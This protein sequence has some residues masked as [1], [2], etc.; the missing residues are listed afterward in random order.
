MY[1]LL[2]FPIGRTA[3]L[4]QLFCYISAEF[5]INKDYIFL[6]PK[7]SSLEKALVCFV[8]VLWDEREIEKDFMIRNSTK[9]VSLTI[10]ILLS[11]IF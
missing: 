11:Y 6:W 2:V 8:I 1:F 5:T 10:D 9:L 3:E 7:F 4:Y